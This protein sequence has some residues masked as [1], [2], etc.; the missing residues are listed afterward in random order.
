MFLT[1]LEST[2]IEIEF[3]IFFFREK[4]GGITFG[5]FM[6]FLSMISKGSTL[7]KLKWAFTFYDVDHDGFITL[8][9]MFKVRFFF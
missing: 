1:F 3:Y 7:D 5:N 2:V 9:E 8:D 6:D 4:T